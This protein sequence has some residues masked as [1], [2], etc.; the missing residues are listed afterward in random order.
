MRNSSRVAAIGLGQGVIDMALG[1][2][3][4][5]DPRNQM[6]NMARTLSDPMGEMRK[7][8]G[9][10]GDFGNYLVNEPGELMDMLDKGW[11]NNDSETLGKGMER[12][13][14]YAGTVAPVAGGAFKGLSKLLRKGPKVCP[15]PPPRGLCFVAGT[16]VFSADGP[17]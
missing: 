11:E 8:G 15:P 9:A 2:L 3:A 10:I 1:T 4:A 17:V 5:A 6:G 16:L 7:L 14:K 12:T 13:A